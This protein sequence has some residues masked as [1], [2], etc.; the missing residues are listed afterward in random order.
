MKESEKELRP[1]WIVKALS[2]LVG[3]VGI[4]IVFMVFFLLYLF[5]VRKMRV[6]F[7]FFGYPIGFLLAYFF[8]QTPY[9]VFKE[10]G[11]RA[12]FQ[13]WICTILGLSVMGLLY[14]P[15]LASVAGF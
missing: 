9:L 8:L 13:L 5:F 4:Y 14:W 6:F 1:H 7:P 10:Y 3:L 11:V 2:C 12:R 15:L